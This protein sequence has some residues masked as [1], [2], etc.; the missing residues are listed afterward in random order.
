[1]PWE[2]LSYIG[3][4]DDDYFGD[5]DAVRSTTD[6]VRYLVEGV[7]RILPAIR[8]ARV[9]GTT[10]GVRPTLFA[11]GPNEDRLSREHEIVDH[12]RDGVPGLYSMIGGKLASYRAFAEQM[13][14]RLAAD[15]DVRA[16]CRTHEV[17]LPGGDLVVPAGPLAERFDVPEVAVR[18]LVYRHGTRADAVLARISARP[19][20]RAVVC[21]CE[22]VLECEVRHA[23][24]HEDART[25]ADVT[26]RTRLGMGACGAM[27]CA[28]RAA[29]IVAEE[30]GLPPSR[31]HAMAAR[32]LV[33]RFR[34]RAVALD[35]AA[36][37]QEE[38]L[39]AH[40]VG[41]GLGADDAAGEEP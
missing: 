8:D 38:V 6:E 35:G 23:C 22:P 18:R 27:R 20:E 40:A 12:A 36:L 11:W 25:L 19:E 37:L 33:D 10:A 13:T 16:P 21:P 5:L 15:L 31:A 4:T 9:I 34:S 1:M 24:R 17:V 7:A 2:N 28:H 32:L 29:V 14:D 3:T 41:S 26:R 30:H 39:I